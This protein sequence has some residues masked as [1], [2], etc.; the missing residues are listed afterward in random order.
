MPI[1]EF[2]CQKCGKHFEA[3]ISIGKE[4][5]VSCGSCGSKDIQKLLSTF[6]IGGGS[7]RLKSSSEACPTCTT[8]TCSTC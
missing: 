4:K 1:Y 3:L 5:D 2:L 6:G 7:S 8:N